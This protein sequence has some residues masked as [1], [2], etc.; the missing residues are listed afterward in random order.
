MNSELL[1]ASR[2][3]LGKG[4]L[5]QAIG[6]SGFFT[7]AFGA[8]VG[9]GWVVVL[10][11][12]LAAA[13]PGGAV[14]GFVLGGC[15][16]GLIALCY[17]E[18]AAHSSSAGVEFI[19]TLE[20]FGR[21]PGFLVGW[22]LTLY[23]MAVCA[24]EG[25]AL[26]W[27]M[28]SLAP[29]VALPAAYYI[30]GHP[31]FW[32]SLVIGLVGAVLVCAI[33][34]RGAASAIRFQNLVTF[35]FIGAS[36]VAIVLG[37]TLGSI[38]NLEPLWPR[39]RDGHAFRGTFWIFATCAFFLNGWQAALYAI[40]EKRPDLSTRRA[41]LATVCAVAAAA[42]FYCCIILAASS[43]VPWRRL[44]VSDLPAVSAFRTLSAPL[45]TFILVAAIISL[46]K[47]WT[48]VAW[49]ASRLLLAQ[50]RHGMLPRWLGHI[51][52]SS[53]VPRRAIVLVT[54]I[55]MIGIAAGRSAIL[56]I[57]NMVSIC[58]ALSTILCLLV[59]LRRRATLDLPGA[60]VVPG[61]RPIIVLALVC[62]VIMVGAAVVAPLLDGNGKIP[63]EWALLAGWGIFGVVLWFTTTSI[64]RRN[65]QAS[66]NST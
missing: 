2:P 53:G 50:A 65:S 38:T 52:P 31:V 24:F 58:N 56:P 35:V 13:D 57:V 54:L 41:I 23:A 6:W 8:I 42:T 5:R 43:A 4:A 37:A 20:T 12:W 51:D 48:A 1:R 3:T 61:G 28:R 49:I 62:A 60:Y 63:P 11:D 66:M 25:V 46:T 16:M 33:H 32:D 29:S 17:G 14:V 21:F 9:S 30:A 59:L 47:T 22:Y 45:G 44:M 36:A 27:L 55:T 10:G 64:A 40:E 7:L 19:Y 15:V 18:L 39:L 34:Y 26:G